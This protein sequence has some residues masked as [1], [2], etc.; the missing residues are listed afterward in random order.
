MADKATVKR[1][2]DLVVGQAPVNVCY[3]QCTSLYPSPIEKLNLRF[4]REL[5]Q[6]LNRPVGFSDHSIGKLVAPLAVAAGAILVEKHFTF[7]SS[8]DGFDHRISLDIDD[9]SD[10]VKAIRFAER[11]LGVGD[12]ILSPPLEDAANTYLR[13]MVFSQSMQ[14][15]TR[16]S[17]ENVDFLRLPPEIDGISPLF[18]DEIVGRV[19]RRSVVAGEVLSFED[20]S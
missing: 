16:I 3:L 11:A 9:F 7:D 18:W 2:H 13:K 12:K 10:M 14:A 17:I 19:L 1:I 4:I 6:L 5:G 8:R 20:I 15:G